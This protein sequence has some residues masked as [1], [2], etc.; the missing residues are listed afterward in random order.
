MYCDPFSSCPDLI[1]GNFPLIL[2]TNPKGKE[3]VVCSYDHTVGMKPYAVFQLPRFL[4]MFF[5][6]RIMM[7]V[8]WVFFSAHWGRCYLLSGTNNSC[9]LPAASSLPGTS[10]QH[11]PRV[12]SL[13]PPNNAGSW[14]LLLSWFLQMWQLQLRELKWHC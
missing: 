7:S 9:H 6:F 12:P 13:N 8:Y 11:L 2:N 14:V 1:V 3:Q 5:M 10:A 4:I